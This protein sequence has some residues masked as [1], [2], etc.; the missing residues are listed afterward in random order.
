MPLYYK[1]VP[2]GEAE[3]L[4]T[5]DVEKMHQDILRD[6]NSNMIAGGIDIWTDCNTF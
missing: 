5:Q 2:H 6:R 3:I 1:W 4:R